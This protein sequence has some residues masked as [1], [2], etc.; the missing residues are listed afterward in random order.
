MLR[1]SLDKMIVKQ[2]IEDFGAMEFRM[3]VHFGLYSELGKGN[4]AYYLFCNNL[5]MR[6]APNVIKEKP[7]G[8]K[9]RVVF[10]FSEKIKSVKWIYND[11]S[12]DFTQSCEK[13][14]VTT[15]PKSYGE[16][17]VVKI[18]KITV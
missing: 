13:A 6:T 10:S 1:F 18:A 14:V 5:S 3:F 12:L 17:M 9:F 7:G 16:S 2:Y 4:G 8:A 15:T 11:E